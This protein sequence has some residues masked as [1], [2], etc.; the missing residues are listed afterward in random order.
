M[1]LQCDLGCLF[2][3]IRKGILTL[4]HMKKLQYSG[5]ETLQNPFSHSAGVEEGDISLLFIKY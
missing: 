1:I 4:D 5:T 2:S 3:S